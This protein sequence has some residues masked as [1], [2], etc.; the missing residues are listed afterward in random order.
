[1]S[2]YLTPVDLR[3][4]GRKR[5]LVLSVLEYQSD[6][7]GR[8][9]RVPQWFETDLDSVPRLPLVYLVAGEQAPA[10]AVVHDWLLETETP[11]PLA[12]KVFREAM[13]VE[14]VATWIRE[15]MY[16]AVRARGW[17]KAITDYLTRFP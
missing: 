4:I 8:V 1:M 5:W 11:W 6:L 17:R 10:S 13:A 3:L 14:G 2:A 7:L 9:V 12:A 15:L 16:A